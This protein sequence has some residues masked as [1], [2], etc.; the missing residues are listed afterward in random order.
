MRDSRPRGILSPADRAYLT[1]EADL[2]SD[3]SEYDARYRIRERIR[4]ALLDF[5]L[6]FEHLAEQ[7][8]RQVFAPDADERDTFTEG[9]V[10]AIAFLYLGTAE[11][12]PPR[13]NLFAEGIRR[14]AE[15]E[16]EDE[17]AFCSVRIDVERPTRAQLERIIRCVEAGAYHELGESELRSLACFMHRRDQ[18]RSDVLER[19][20]TAL[21]E[22]QET[23]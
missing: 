6:L 23:P 2:A 11:Y 20:K 1:G 10:S 16:H 7:D 12:D 17:S 13:E 21:D 5:G 15:R 22:E 4:H 19:L 3:Q 9:L 18:G 8:C 14:A